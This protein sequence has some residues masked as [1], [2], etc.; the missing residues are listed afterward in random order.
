MTLVGPATIR[1]QQQPPLPLS[2]SG[3]RFIIMD[4][5]VVPGRRLLLTDFEH[6]SVLLV[7]SQE[8]RVLSIVTVASEPWGVCMVHAACAAV[9]LP[10]DKR[11]K[12]V[13]VNS[14]S[15]T[16][17]K[18]VAVEGDVRGVSV[19][20]DGLV[21]TCKNPPAVEV[22][23]QEGKRLHR[24]DNKSACRE[25]FEQPWYVAVS[26]DIVFVSDWSTHA[27]T[28]L[29]DQLQLLATFSQP[30][31]LNV[32]H[33]IISLNDDQLLV[34]GR[35]SDNIVLLQPS[36]GRMSA[37]LEEKDGVE[38]PVA[39][40]FCNHSRTLYITLESPTNIIQRYKLK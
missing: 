29:S 10:D 16:L 2:S 30:D 34:C 9:A 8:G 25:L 4:M 15:L 1:L 20:G 36:S 7:D 27:I 19:L 17:G 32:P 39:L 24:F 31:L 22:V 6:N 21:V 14:D 5:V 38:L 18:F 12:Y 37:I 35:W 13:Y 33:G 28:M 40:A 11:V 23:T 3:Q 26:G